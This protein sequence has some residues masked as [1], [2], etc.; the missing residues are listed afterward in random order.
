MTRYHYRPDVLAELWR[1]GVQPRDTTPPEL[2]RGYVNDLYRYE[3]RRL[4][5]RLLAGE[6][7]KAGYYDVVVETRNRYRVLAIKAPHWTT[8]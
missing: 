3:L 8:P 4:R 2:V 7:A 5:A 1:H 6:I